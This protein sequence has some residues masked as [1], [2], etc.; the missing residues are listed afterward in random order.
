MPHYTATR[1]DIG[2]KLRMVVR[3]YFAD[4]SAGKV[5]TAITE[6]EVVD[7]DQL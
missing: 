6:T 7:Y 2:C 3:P 4:G 5:A 1:Q